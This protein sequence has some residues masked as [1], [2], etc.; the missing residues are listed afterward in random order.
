MV[1][2]LRTCNYNERTLARRCGKL[3]NWGSAGD[4]I[5]IER[6]KSCTVQYRIILQGSWLTIC[7]D[8]AGG[9][10]PASLLVIGVNQQRRAR[11]GT[12]KHPLPRPEREG[13]RATNYSLT[14][15]YCSLQEYLGPYTA[16]VL[17]HNRDSH[18]Y[19]TVQSAVRGIN[20]QSCAEVILLPS[21]PL[22]S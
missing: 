15:R 2:V 3:E 16:T 14:K 11:Q 12:A 22:V 10:N 6:H 20:E 8:I 21:E 13:E 19:F 1:R 9:A 7:N 5:A 17:T 18:K 4:P